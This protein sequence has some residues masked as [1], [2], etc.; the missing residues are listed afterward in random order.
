MEGKPRL[1]G[2]V[3]LTADSFSDGG[4]YLDPT[5]AVA[6]A[7]R[8]AA[9]GADV[10][11]LGPA[12]THP[13]AAPVPA[14]EEIRRLAPVLDA[15]LSE[16][17]ALSVDSREPETQRYALG[18]GVAYLND[19]AGFPDPALYPE[20]AAARA[21]LVVMHAVRE[22]GGATR[23][24]LAPARVLD[25]I[26]AFF[27]RRVAALAAAGVARERL[28]LDPGMGFFLGGSAAASLAVL[29]DLP[30][31]RRTFGLPVLVSV[32]RKSFL[33]ELTGRPVAERGAATLA[34]ELH[35]AAAGA[36][37]LRTHDVGALRDALAVA[38]ALGEPADGAGREE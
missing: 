15:L 27:E 17:L 2:V 20:L 7:H 1:V 19:V 10:V 3:N 36:D 28:V 21:S 8:L 9:E 4:R 5:A 13:D 26:Y 11:E 23:E 31:L 35:A 14:A 29:R 16:G 32:S 12:S 30:R 25:G 18:R 22:S 34:A 33:G 37:Y 24:A 38:R 6:H